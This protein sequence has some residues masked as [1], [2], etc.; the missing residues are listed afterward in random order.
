MRR[1][2]V[3]IG[4]WALAARVELVVGR[5]ASTGARVDRFLARR[6]SSV[7]RSELQRWIEHG[8]VTVDGVVRDASAKLREGDRVVGR[9]RSR[10][11]R[12]AP[13]PD[14]GVEFEVLYVDDDIVVVEQAAGPRR[15]PGAR[16]RGAAR[17]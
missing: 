16:P 7:S 14:E 13:L 3:A 9:A 2:R 6:R 11:R 1:R 10:R 5:E 15:A 17:S 8:R 12:P 4:A